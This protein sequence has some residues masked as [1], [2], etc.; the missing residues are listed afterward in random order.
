VASE[1]GVKGDRQR[2]A[3]KGITGGELLLRVWRQRV[4]GIVAILFYLAVGGLCVWLGTFE[5]NHRQLFVFKPSQEQGLPASQHAIYM[6]LTLPSRPANT[7]DEL[8]IQWI[9]TKTEI[10]VDLNHS[11]IRFPSRPAIAFPPSDLLLVN[12]QNDV[13]AHDLE[14]TLEHVRWLV[15]VNPRLTTANPELQPSFT[16]VRAKLERLHPAVAAFWHH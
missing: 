4:L 7:L 3:L 1:T 12:Q 10:E 2:Q 9:L 14:R 5:K 11:E 8:Q 13:T 15:K 6:A 16:Q